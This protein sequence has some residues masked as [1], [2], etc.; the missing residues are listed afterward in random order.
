MKGE[1]EDQIYYSIDLSDLRSYLIGF[2]RV[3][4]LGDSF[5]SLFVVTSKN[6]IGFRK[7]KWKTPYERSIYEGDGFSGEAPQGGFADA[8]VSPCRWS[9]PAT[10]CFFL[11]VR[12]SSVY[13]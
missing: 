11:V 13:L 1:D 7:E 3:I 10:N 6:P 2:Y 9:N 5:I 8:P 12:E 4:T